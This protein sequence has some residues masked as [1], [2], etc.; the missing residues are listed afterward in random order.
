MKDECIGIQLF[1]YKDSINDKAFYV[2]RSLDTLAEPDKAILGIFITEDALLKRI[3]FYR[4]YA[5]IAQYPIEYEDKADAL[6]SLLPHK[7]E[8]NDEKELI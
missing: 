8:K 4:E 5:E 6:E 7:I 1:A 2:H 3:K